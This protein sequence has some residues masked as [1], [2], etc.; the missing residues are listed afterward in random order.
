MIKLKYLFFEINFIF[1]TYNL[2]LKLGYNIMRIRNKNKLMFD[3]LSLTAILACALFTISSVAYADKKAEKQLNETNICKK[4]D[5]TGAYLEN[6]D[7]YKADLYG[8]NLTKANLGGASLGRANLKFAN[9]T[10]AYLA[11]AN[12]G[13][14]N[15]VDANLA[16]AN[17]KGA[18]LEG[19]NL[20][21]VRYCKTR[22][23]DKTTNNSG[24]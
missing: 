1:I 24:C 3:H 2:K 23:P 15:L 19:A 12:L 14:A 16:N 11:G 20:K 22:M 9:L 10:G 21:G 18:N 4:C 6:A 7:L 8:A 17:L 5:L 13:G